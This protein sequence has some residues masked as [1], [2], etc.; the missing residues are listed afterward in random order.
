M[1]ISRK[2]PGQLLPKGRDSWD[3]TIKRLQAQVAEM[4]QILVDNK[5]MK[6]A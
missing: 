5:L 3:I 1:A 4:T 6:L 2:R